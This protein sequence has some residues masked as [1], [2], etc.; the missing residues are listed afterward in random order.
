MSERPSHT[1][2][3]DSVPDSG[4]LPLS[5]HPPELKSLFRLNCPTV[6]SSSIGRARS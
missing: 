2:Q 1:S 5:S 3:R 4:P 6:P